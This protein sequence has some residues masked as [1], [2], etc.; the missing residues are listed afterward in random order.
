MSTSRELTPKEQFI[1]QVKTDF[2]Y[3]GDISDDQR[4][5]LGQVQRAFAEAR[6]TLQ[7]NV[8]TPLRHNNR[9][10]DQHFEVGDHYL[11]SAHRRANAAV[12]K[13]WADT[14]APMKTEAVMYEAE[15]IEDLQQTLC[16]IVS[17]TF[18]VLSV[19]VAT[20]IPYGRYASI[21]KTQL[22]EARGEY[23]QAVNAAFESGKLRD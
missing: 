8:R 17:R 19:N 9:E 18:Y 5:V 12:V 6:E 23:L 10:T 16:H 1:E 2:T 11:N 14:D 7:I 15:T 20:Y 13:D 4:S 22:E 3:T 21:F